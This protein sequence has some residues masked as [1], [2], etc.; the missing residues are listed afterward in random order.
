MTEIGMT[1]WPWVACIVLSVAAVLLLHSLINPPP[2]AD[3]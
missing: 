2:R 1:F 3:R